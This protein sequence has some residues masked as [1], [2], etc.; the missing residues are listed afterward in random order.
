MKIQT[1]GAKTAPV[2]QRLY[3]VQPRT[4]RA[5]GLHYVALVLEGDTVEN[6]TIIKIKQ[7]ELET[8]ME[9]LKSL[10]KSKGYY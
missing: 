10:S 7:S 3:M 8:F 4:D 5:T 2:D 9:K 1:R 6:D